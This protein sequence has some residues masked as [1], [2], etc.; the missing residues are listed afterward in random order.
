MKRAA[1][2]WVD[3]RKAVLVIVTDEG[4]EIKRIEENHAPTR[5]SA[6]VYLTIGGSY[7]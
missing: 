3:H 5:M 7:V 4:E 1:G 2:L 6:I